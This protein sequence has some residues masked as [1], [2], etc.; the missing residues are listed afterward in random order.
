MGLDLFPFGLLK[1][2][3]KMFWIHGLVVE[4]DLKSYETV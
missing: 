2:I 4:M 3:L 1:Y